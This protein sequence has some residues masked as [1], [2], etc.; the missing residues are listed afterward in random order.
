MCLSKNIF[1]LNA[2]RS[3]KHNMVLLLVL[4]DNE[5]NGSIIIRGNLEA[6]NKPSSR[7]K[8][9]DRF[10]FASSFLCNLFANLAINDCSEES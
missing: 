8:F 10:C 3:Q 7:S 2:T 9:Q 6:S 4:K 5:L 1:V